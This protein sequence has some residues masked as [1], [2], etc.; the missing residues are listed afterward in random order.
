ML[1]P[2]LRTMNIYCN[3]KTRFLFCVCN[4][5]LCA[6][7]I[8]YLTRRNSS[9]TSNHSSSCQVAQFTV[10]LLVD[11]SDQIGSFYLHNPI[12][13]VKLN[14]IIKGVRERGFKLNCTSVSFSCLFHYCSS[15]PTPFA[16]LV[17]SSE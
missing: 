15:H 16:T 11:V 7:K 12:L 14:T 13:F 2:F 8:H 6:M 1:S 9:S 5:S 17:Q 4:F 10:I 3:S